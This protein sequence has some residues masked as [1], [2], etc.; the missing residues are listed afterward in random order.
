VF[1]LSGLG[2]ENDVSRVKRGDRI[3]TFE[4][5]WARQWKRRLETLYRVPPILTRLFLRVICFLSRWAKRGNTSLTYSQDFSN[6]LKSWKL[7]C[8]AAPGRKPH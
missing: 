8:C 7:V 4:K 5:H 3:K 2:D 6:F 1:A